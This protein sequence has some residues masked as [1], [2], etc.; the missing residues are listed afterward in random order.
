MR[1][2]IL[3]KE[4]MDLKDRFFD[5]D[6]QQQAIFL[7][8][9]DPQPELQ[10]AQKPAAKKPRKP[11]GK[12]ARAVSLAEQVKRE[13]RSLDG[14]VSKMRCSY[15]NCGEYQD[16]AVHSPELGGRGYHYFRVDDTDAWPVC[17]TC[18]NVEDY[19]DHSSP[20]PNYHEFQP[21]VQVAAG[22]GS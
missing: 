1:S 3:T 22:G 12:S 9:V 5:M 19:V 2:D 14:G 17:V 15:E 6:T 4:L 10:A 13:S 18:G 7:D 21:P 11:R 20:S 8:L 16:N